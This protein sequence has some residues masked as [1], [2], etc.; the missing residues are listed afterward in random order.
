MKN[1]VEYLTKKLEELKIDEKDF[2]TKFIKNIIDEIS[3]NYNDINFKDS[4]KRITSLVDTIIY[5]S[6]ESS[7]DTVYPVSFIIKNILI[8]DYIEYAKTNI[9]SD[10]YESKILFNKDGTV[11]NK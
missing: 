10:Y 1:Y 8:N 6:N 5:D 2:N 7:I 4:N 11:I 3:S 9:I